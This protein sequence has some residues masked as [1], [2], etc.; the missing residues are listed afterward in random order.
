MFLVEEIDDEL[1]KST[2]HQNVE[3]LGLTDLMIASLIG[4]LRAVELI[5]K[6]GA[7]LNVQHPQYGQ[8]ALSYAAQRGHSDIVNK[9]LELGATIGRAL[10]DA[11]LSGSN[12]SIEFILEHDISVANKQEPCGTPLHYACVAKKD[13]PEALELLW[14]YKA[15]VNA[16]DDGG[17]TPIMHAAKLGRTRYME[18]LINHEA[19]LNI[20]STDHLSVLMYAASSGVPEAVELL[21]QHGADISFIN[22]NDE[23]CLSYA[24]YSGGAPVLEVILKHWTPPHYR[25]VKATRVADQYANAAAVMVLGR[26]YTYRRGREAELSGDYGLATKHYDMALRAILNESN[27]KLNA[28]AIEALHNWQRAGFMLLYSVF[29]IMQPLYRQ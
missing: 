8:T 29:C 14:K 10:I 20:T 19:H 9:L 21:I 11:V 5:A 22:A 27:G 24:A 23:D 16:L 13:N 1:I 17:R 25:L 6:S 12:A 2:V 26:H 3:D 4:D 28:F 15:D 7:D 18:I